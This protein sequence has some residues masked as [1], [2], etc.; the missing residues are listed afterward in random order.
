M[1]PRRSH[2]RATETQELQRAA[3]FRTALRRFLRRTDEAAAAA[4]L[5]S[6]R[7]NLLLQIKAAADRGA[8]ATVTSLTQ[9]LH[10]PQTAVTEL[11]RRATRHG[12]I[13]KTVNPRDRRSNQLNLTKE[14]NAK[15]IAA[16]RALRADRETLA[17]AL[18]DAREIDAVSTR[19][20]SLL[21]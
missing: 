20:R 21:A 10:L 11:V 7:Y 12:L 2:T 16:F 18:N 14:G 5:T 3:A 19:E 13:T 6:Q 8:P 1:P 9:T 15:V 17:D 4:G